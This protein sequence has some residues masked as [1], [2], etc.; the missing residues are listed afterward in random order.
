[1][2]NIAGGPYIKVGDQAPRLLADWLKET[3]PEN[4]DVN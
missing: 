4:K 2:P 3:H 1:M